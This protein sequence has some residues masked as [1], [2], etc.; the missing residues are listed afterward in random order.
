MYIGGLTIMGLLFFPEIT[1]VLLVGG[2][3]LNAC[4]G[5]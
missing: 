2:F 5:G 3:M 4:A 1:I